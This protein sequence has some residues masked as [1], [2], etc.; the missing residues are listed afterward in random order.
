VPSAAEVTGL[1]T[2]RGLALVAGA[3]ALTEVHASP[4]DLD[5]L[6]RADARAVVA[7]VAVWAADVSAV[8]AGLGAG[9]FVADA[10][11][12]VRVA[13]EAREVVTRRRT[14]VARDGDRW[15]LVPVTEPGAPLP[16]ELGD[17][18]AHRAPRGVV[19]LTAH[20]GELDDGAPGDGAPGGTAASAT[21]TGDATRGAGGALAAELAA[22][23][24][25]AARRVDAA[26][27]TDWPRATAVVLPATAAD[28]A[29]LAGVAAQDVAALDA[30]AVGEEADLPDGRPGGVRVVVQ[31]ARFPQLTPLGRRVTLTHE[32]VHVATR[33][34]TTVAGAGALPRWL[35]E[36]FADLVAREGRPLPA[37]A[38][39]RPLLDAVAAG[40]PVTVP[41]DAAF[42]AA[43]AIELQIAYASAWTLVASVARRTAAGAVAGLYRGLA[44]APELG[45]RPAAA[46]AP[47]LDAGCVRA[48]GE[49]FDDVRR[50]WVA[51]VTGGLAGWS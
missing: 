32:L 49:T 46:P 17:V 34:A 40:R 43:D 29:R 38:L 3:D 48:F 13:G 10:L 12:R 41:D 37:T 33:A 44:S 50:R 18:E 24:A 5:R 47:R 30:L 16:W 21:A 7:G 15:V 27:G 20:D 8:A 45:G 35:V 36:G 9:T 1:L 31:P 51:D 2:R 19:L 14:G 25:D 28:A 42:G 26:W 6:R 22:D 23:L 4:A 11:L 39:A